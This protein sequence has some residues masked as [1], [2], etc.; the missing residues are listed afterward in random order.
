MR[1]GDPGEMSARLEQLRLVRHAREAF[2]LVAGDLPE[3][4]TPGWRGPA[5]DL[6]GARA[7]ELRIAATSALATMAAAERTL[8]RALGIGDG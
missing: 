3:G 6:A 4:E 7:T 5:A 1:A 2:E 8:A